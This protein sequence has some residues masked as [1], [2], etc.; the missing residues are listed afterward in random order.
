MGPA[1]FLTQPLRKAKKITLEV[2][3]LPKADVDV[4]VHQRTNS[5]PFFHV[6]GVLIPSPEPP[7]MAWKRPPGEAGD[8][9]ISDF[10]G[11]DLFGTRD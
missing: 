10:W 8:R 3:Q 4:A 5:G 6:L 11:V 2:W 1:Y 7:S 9:L